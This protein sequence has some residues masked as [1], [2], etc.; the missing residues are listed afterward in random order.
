MK[1]LV[2]PPPPGAAAD[3]W[4]HQL[5]GQEAHGARAAAD[6]EHTH[7]LAD[8]CFSQGLPGAEPA[9][10]TTSAALAGYLTR[11]TAAPTSAPIILEQGA[12]MG[13]PAGSKCA[14]N[15]ARPGR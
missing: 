5:G 6:M 7:S 12:E 4:A 2:I 9:S 3:C 14:A 10:G 11:H 8:P 1:H 13:R 15:A